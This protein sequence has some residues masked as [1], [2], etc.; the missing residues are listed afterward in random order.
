MAFGLWVLVWGVG[1]GIW[2]WGWVCCFVLLL[3]WGGGV[4][5]WL[6]VGLRRL[7]FR[8]CRLH[9]EERHGRRRHTRKRPR[10]RPRRRPTRRPR[11]RPPGRRRR[12]RGT[13][14]GRRGTNGTRSRSCSR[15][16][17]S[18]GHTVTERR[19]ETRTRGQ[20]YGLT[21]VVFSSVCLFVVVAFVLLDFR[22]SCVCHVSPVSAIKLGSGSRTYPS[23][24]L[25][26]WAQRE[27]EEAPKL[28]RGLG[29]R[30]RDHE[31]R[32]FVVALGCVPCVCACASWLS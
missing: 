12:R 28:H 8:A 11:R 1:C 30:D 17:K 32:N 29:E 25:G 9:P 15:T 21:F 24:M 2:D 4:A 3:G 10:R 26:P 14:H 13:N 18:S 19:G 31:R 22:R 27:T 16:A 5:W 7:G 20:T 23:R 6:G